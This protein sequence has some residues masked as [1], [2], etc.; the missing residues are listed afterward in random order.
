MNLEVTAVTFNSA[1][2]N[3]ASGK[4]QRVDCE[5]LDEI[6]HGRAPGAKYPTESFNVQGG[7]QA[8]IWMG[9]LVSIARATKSSLAI[10]FRGKSANPVAT[11]ANMIYR[12]IRIGQDK[13]TIGLYGY[14]FEHG[15]NADGSTEPLSIG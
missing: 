12:G 13:D 2:Y 7:A 4:P 8:T 14:V 11:F 1:T 9:E 3:S 5:A 10:T 6:L 15:D